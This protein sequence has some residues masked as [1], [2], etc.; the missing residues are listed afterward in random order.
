MTGSV[1]KLPDFSGGYD[2]ARLNQTMDV[3]LEAGSEAS[4]RYALVHRHG[5]P[6]VEA[7]GYTQAAQHCF[8]NSVDP[9]QL[10]PEVIH[11]T[12][13]RLLAALDAA[14]GT[15][16]EP[17]GLCDDTAKHRPHLHDVPGGER[18]WCTADRAAGGEP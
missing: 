13:E 18:I 2:L 11:T 9:N 3:V 4:G 16:E 10:P 14:V 6:A 1:V 5:W 8:D 12:P 17:E 7:V 15:G